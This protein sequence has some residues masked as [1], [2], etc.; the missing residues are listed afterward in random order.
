M[1]SRPTDH[2]DAALPTG[3]IRLADLNDG[4]LRKRQVSHLQ[5]IYHAGRI[6]ARNRGAANILAGV[7]TH[8]S[9]RTIQVRSSNLIERSSGFL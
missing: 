7:F 1:A 3:G 4:F 9:V 5:V 2:G 6:M 8:E